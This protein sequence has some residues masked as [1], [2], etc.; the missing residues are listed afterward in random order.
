VD[1]STRKLRYFVAV[2]EELN[3]SRA[4]ERL[5]VAQQ[6][7]SKQVRELEESLGTVLLT[8]S[9]RRVELTPAGASFLETARSVL[10]TLDSGVLAAQQQGREHNGTLRLGFLVGAALELTAPITAEF[11]ARCPG[12]RIDLREYSFSDSSAGLADDSV[13]VALLR[14]PVSL[15]GLRFEQLFVEPLMLMVPRAHRLAAQTSLS[16]RQ[17]LDE[18]LA[19]G[20]SAD[21][22][23]RAFWTLQAYRGSSAAAVAQEVTSQTELLE[24]VASGIACA[25]TIA[26]ASRY[27]THPDVCYVP[28]EDA[29]GAMLG[30]GWRRESALVDQFVAAAQTVRERQV[31]TVR[32]IERPYER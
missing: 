21:P 26:G 24:V 12:V 6:A 7:L 17:I 11:A 15:Q 10:D 29:D 14:A 32:Q 25:V 19:V 5:Y 8:R 23:W 9:T 28:I 16:V 2:A 1:L 31:A 20:R 13:D 18:P 27:T 3:F 22:A 30:I 4:A